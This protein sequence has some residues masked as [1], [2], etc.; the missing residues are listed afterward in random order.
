[1]HDCSA[2]KVSESVKELIKRSKDVVSEDVVVPCPLVEVI[3]L[4]K[5]HRDKGHIAQRIGPN[6]VEISQPC[7]ML[8]PNI[9]QRL[10]L[11]GEALS[12]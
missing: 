12:K 1:M 6:R 7:N 5:F 8:M 3:A 4:D 10:P 11:I 9:G 2:V